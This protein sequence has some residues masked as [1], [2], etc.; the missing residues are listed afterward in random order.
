MGR[1][2]LQTCFSGMFPNVM[3][4]HC[5]THPHCLKLESCLVEYLLMNLKDT[6]RVRMTKRTL[7]YTLVRAALE[8]D[9][10]D[11]IKAGRI[12]LRS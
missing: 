11:P 10:A 4:R 1:C 6:A 3:Y 5:G 8:A 7:F 9:F 12:W 2:V